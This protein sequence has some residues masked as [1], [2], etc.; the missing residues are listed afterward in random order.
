MFAGS[1][2]RN[3]NREKVT[4]VCNSVPYIQLEVVVDELHNSSH[5]TAEDI[6][7]VRKDQKLDSE[8]IRTS[9]NSS[10]VKNKKKKKSNPQI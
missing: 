10:L 3:A 2:E 5:I 1:H 7:R 6:S 8:L 4:R 9:K